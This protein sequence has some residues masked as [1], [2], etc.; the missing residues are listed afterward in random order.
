[1]AVQ[2]TSGVCIQKMGG[3]NVTVLHIHIRIALRRLLWQA[4]ANALWF[5]SL[6]RTVQH[7]F[8]RMCLVEKVA[9]DV[10]QLRC[11]VWI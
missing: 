8:D 7:V 11:K 10:G 5:A 3:T 9:E 6:D 2:I 1:M 4:I